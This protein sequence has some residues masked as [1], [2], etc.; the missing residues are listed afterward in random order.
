ME[1]GCFK[2]TKEVKIVHECDVLVVGGGLGGVAA[3]IAS[4]RAGANTIL[5][6]RNTFLGGVAT[7]GHCCSIFN[8]MYS[9]DHRLLVQGLP[10]EIAETLAVNAGPGS[11]WQNHRGHVIYDIEL[12]KIA[13]LEM[14]K[15]AGVKVLLGSILSDTI[16]ED[17]EIRGVIFTGRY[18]LEGISAK[19]VVD[20]TGDADVAALAGANYKMSNTKSSYC[21]RVGNVDV[22]KFVQYFVDHPGEYP[23]QMD[24]EWTFE[25]ALAQ[26]REN[27]TFLFPHGGG[28]QLSI[29]KKAL[30]EGRYSEVWED[31]SDMDAMQMHAIRRNGTIHFITGFFILDTLNTDEMTE[32]NL[33]GKRMAVHVTNFL[34][35]NFPGFENCYLC[36]TA[37][38]LGIR[39]S[40]YIQSEFIYESQMRK[41]PTRFEDSVGRVLI[42]DGKK[43]HTGE[44][45]WG[46]QTLGSDYTE[47]PL[48]CLLPT[49]PEGLIMGAGRSI[50][51]KSPMA[52]RVMV[53]TM[54]I[55]QG[56]GITAAVSVKNGTPI[57]K[58]DYALIREELVRQNVYPE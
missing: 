44:G 35:D 13:L 33:Q 55:G 22:D 40:R 8:C 10:F 31:I 15:E 18:G 46:V 41:E 29:V 2:I 38:D 6:E 7:A 42:V 1:N 56:A 43:V 54:V 9:G 53:N 36:S 57:D 50:S 52:L 24:V 11:S 19:R 27:G 32:R 17:G 12:G 37:D 14:A 21:F 49:A 4:A 34:R 28:H 48:R 3:A 39:S 58:T 5:M 25:D 23:D 51:A 26:Y 45:A 30:A 20:A 16:V 47:V